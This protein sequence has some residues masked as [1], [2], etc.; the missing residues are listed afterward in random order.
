[1]KSRRL[2]AAIAAS[3]ALAACSD[4]PSG[5]GAVPADAPAVRQAGRASQVIP[6]RYIV[7]F[8]SDVRDAPG[9]AR[10]LAAAH[11]ATVHHTYQHAIKGFAATLPEGAAAA[12]RRNPAVAY[13]EQDQRVTL[14]QAGSWGLDRVDQ[15]DLPLNGSYT[16]TR[17]GA[18]VKAYI[19]DTGIQ[20]S[21][22]QFGGRASVGYDAVGDGMN[23]QDCNGHGT[24]VA[25]TVGSTTYG[26]AKSVALVAVRVFPCSGGSAWSTIIAGVDW[27]RFNHV[28][29]AVAN[30]SLGGGASQAI[31]DA[32]RSL[33]AAGVTVAIAAGNDYGVDACTVSPARVGEAL[34]VGATTSSDVKADFSNIG[35]CLDLFAPGQGITSTWLSGGTNTIDGTSMATPH[36]TGA[37]ALYLEGAPTASPATV[38]SAIVSNATPNRLSGI[39]AGSPNLLLYTLT[40]GTTPPPGPLSV[41]IAGPTA[42]YT[43]GTY[44]YQA[45]A[46][47]GNGTYS[48]AWEYM[49]SP[50]IYASYH[51]TGTNS[52]AYSHTFVTGAYKVALRVTVTSGG[53]TASNV[54]LVNKY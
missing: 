9:L 33:I 5:P 40:G 11:G 8:R 3:L 12:L 7:V 2:F 28:K 15:R 10:Q 19:I 22:A 36:V 25:G 37:A 4:A 1:M 31:D 49:N 43:P 23:G 17:T 32:V 45:N 18:G 6:N 46:T 24:H 16:Y 44:A 47:G 35:S 27:V 14:A 54:I 26:V 20:T 42:I 13:V 52:P 51:P 38:G 30:M 34:T 29:P 50:F 21:H 53:T 41:T 48:Y 39:G